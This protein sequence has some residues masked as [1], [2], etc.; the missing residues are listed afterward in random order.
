MRWLKNI[1]NIA[2]KNAPGKCPF[3]NSLNTDYSAIRIKNEYGYCVIWCNDCKHAFN[4]SRIS[5]TEGMNVG[6]SIPNNLIF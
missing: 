2:E 6:K 3:C 4:V 1:E 5:I